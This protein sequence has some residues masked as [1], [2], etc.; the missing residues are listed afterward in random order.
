VWILNAGAAD[1]HDDAARQIQFLE[2]AVR[3]QA[4]ELHNLAADTLAGDRYSQPH[5]SL[6][7]LTI[8]GTGKDVAKD[9]PCPQKSDVT[10]LGIA[11]GRRVIQKA[12]VLL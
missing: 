12:E 3:A 6:A 5:L 10:G 9:S 2:C 11:R 8:H 1:L 7:M 4:G